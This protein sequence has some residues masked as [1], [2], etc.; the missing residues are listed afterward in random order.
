ML[1]QQTNRVAFQGAQVQHNRESNGE[2]NPEQISF[3]TPTKE[4]RTS[5]LIKLAQFIVLFTFQTNR[6]DLE[7]AQGRA[8]R[9]G[10]KF[11]PSFVSIAIASLPEHAFPRGRLSTCKQLA[12]GNS[13]LL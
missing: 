4:Q 10:T 2:P 6:A 11:R 12:Q 3:Q 1:I 5:I 8:T 13:E 9:S 7:E